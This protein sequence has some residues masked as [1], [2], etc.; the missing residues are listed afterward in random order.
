MHYIPLNEQESINLL[1]YLIQQQDEYHFYYHLNAFDICYYDSINFKKY[2]HIPF[3]QPFETKLEGMVTI[4]SFSTNQNR[5]QITIIDENEHRLTLDTAT[6]YEYVELSSALSAFHPATPWDALGSM[7][8][9]IVHKPANYL[10]DLEQKHFDL[11]KEI[12]IFHL[13]SN[14][15]YYTNDE[16]QL[17]LNFKILPAYAK[18]YKK[19][20]LYKAFHQ[21][22]E[23][24]LSKRKTALKTL[25][26]ELNKVE[27]SF[28]FQGFYQ[29]IEESQKDYPK[30]IQQVYSEHS[31]QSLHH[32]IDN[33]MQQHD[34]VG[35]FPNYQKE[36][37]QDGIKFLK[38][39]QHTYVKMHPK[40]VS[41]HIHCGESFSENIL[42]L[43]FLCGM[44][45]QKNRKVNNIFTLGFN[46]KDKGFLTSYTI[47]YDPNDD[48]GHELSLLLKIVQRDKLSKEE[49]KETLITLN[50][51]GF[52][53]HTI[54]SGFLFAFIMM[55]LMLGVV[56]I[57][58]MDLIQNLSPYFLP[59]FLFLMFGYGIP[60]GIC[61][62][63]ARE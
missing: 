59:M 28:L 53:I 55:V 17:H 4:D 38:A 21:Y 37:R 31:I 1:Q 46:Q 35:T 13:A 25:A 50:W 45:Y 30:L 61:E 2:L 7:A 43:Q 5:Y 54:F 18:K 41:Y 9:N 47:P 34:Y 22:N 19:A 20:S 44:N 27:Y 14:I 29:L 12:A 48:F 16:K 3:D 52:F 6:L 58:Q 39:Y 42:Y 8:Y 10:N 62:L 57:I 56:S 32:Q 51:L 15:H 60:N 63:L 23:T 36:C 24:E 49:R 40:Y 33:F 26:F 11:F